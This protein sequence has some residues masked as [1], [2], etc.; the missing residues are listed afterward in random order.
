MAADSS[1]GNTDQ[2]GDSSYTGLVHGTDSHGNDATASFGRD[3]GSR[4]GHTLLSD[5]HKTASEFYGQKNSKGHD[6]YDGKD[7]GTQRGQYTGK[8][9]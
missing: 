5:G 4:E 9:S 1:G 6:H 2:G 8:G 7:G 3:G